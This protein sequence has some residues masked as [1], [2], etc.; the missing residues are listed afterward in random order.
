MPHELHGRHRGAARRLPARTRPHRRARRQ[1]RHR[2]LRSRGRAHPRP[3][4]GGGARLHPRHAGR[5]LSRPRPISTTTAPATT[6]VP[7][8]VK[9]IVAG[10]EL[11]VDYSEHR[12][13]RPKGPINSGYFGGGQTTAR[14][15]FKYLM[16]ADEMANE[17]TFRPIKLILPHGKLL[18]A[19]PT[20]P[21]FMYPTPFPDRRS[22]PSSRRWKTRCRRACPAA[23]FGTHSGVRFYRPA[24]R[25]A[26]SSTATT[27]ATAAGAPAPPTTAPARS[28][29][30]RMATPAS[31]R[32]S[33]R[34]R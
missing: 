24:R 15:A 31:S 18:S 33:C 34:S 25:T 9:V 3:V 28:A 8:K 5:R 6:P 30:W 32:W 4:G 21:M 11:T 10:D 7:I 19:D 16:G 14:V 26:R 12:R 27:A 23:H 29:P 1:I 2:D 17:G 13:A 20:A 22:T